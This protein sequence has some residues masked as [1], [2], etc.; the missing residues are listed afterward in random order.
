MKEEG[1]RGRFVCLHRQMFSSVVGKY[2]GQ[3]NVYANVHLC[4]VVCTHT[5]SQYAA[6]ALKIL[7]KTGKLRRLGTGQGGVGEGEK[8][9]FA[10][11]FSI[12]WTSPC[13]IKTVPP[14][15]CTYCNHALSH[16]CIG[17]SK[18]QVLHGRQIKTIRCKKRLDACHATA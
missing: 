6:S 12:V 8:C 9:T 16:I 11:S 10:I 2:G 7:G 15:L 13:Q 4:S 5:H 18:V 17:R 14:L 3:V 1:G